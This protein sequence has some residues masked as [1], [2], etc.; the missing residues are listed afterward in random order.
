MVNLC[1]DE[2]TVTLKHKIDHV[3]GSSFNTNGLGGVLTCGVSGVKAGLSHAP[4]SQTTGREKYVFF[5]FPHISIDSQARQ[6]VI[7]RPG[8]RG[9]S[10]A[11]GALKGALDAIQTQGL[12]ANCK[13]PGGEGGSV[14]GPGG[15]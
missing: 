14:P 6:G 15:V 12:G 3:F 7:S 5:S 9:D 8:R 2:I 4:C 10:C 1:R 11:C 13:V